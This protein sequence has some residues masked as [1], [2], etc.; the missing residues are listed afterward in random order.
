MISSFVTVREAGSLLHRVQIGLWQFVSEVQ[1]FITF[2]RKV[3][4]QS[5]KKHLVT[6]T[7]LDSFSVLYKDINLTRRVYGPS[8]HRVVVT[9][10]LIA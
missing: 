3:F 5:E 10:D 8:S 2:E 6:A 1:T 4:F 9:F 7:V